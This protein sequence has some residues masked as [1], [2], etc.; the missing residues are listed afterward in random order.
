[1]KRLIV[2]LLSALLVYACIPKEEPNFPDIRIP[3]TPVNM[4]DINS[5]YDDY[6]SNIPWAGIT[7]PLCFSSDRNS[8]GKDFDIVYKLLDVYWSFT[9][10]ILIVKEN[11]S[12]NLDVY[13]SNSNINGALQIINSSS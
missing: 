13:S 2:I 4:E 8:K 11:T 10:G 6:N 7:S 5:E 1:M 3:E 12:S 9:K